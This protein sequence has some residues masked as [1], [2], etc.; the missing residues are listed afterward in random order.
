MKLVFINIIFLQ[1]QDNI[2]PWKI[3]V[4]ILLGFKSFRFKIL[5]IA[6]PELFIETFGLASK[7]LWPSIS[8]NASS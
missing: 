8:I 2:E 4:Q 7:M 6:T 1:E 3:D 5:L